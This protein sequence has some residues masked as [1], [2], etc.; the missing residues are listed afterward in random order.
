MQV[1][2]AAWGGCVETVGE[3]GGDERGGGERGGGERGGGAI[4][5]AAVVGGAGGGGA[6]SLSLR[7]WPDDGW[8]GLMSRQRRMHASCLWTPGYTMNSPPT[9]RSVSVHMRRQ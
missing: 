4:P 1:S 8:Q 3:G 5:T 2:S 7:R 6:L 9:G